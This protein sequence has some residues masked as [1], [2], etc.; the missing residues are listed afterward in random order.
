MERVG[1]CSLSMKTFK[2]NSLI[3]TDFNHISRA[4]YLKYRTERQWN[5]FYEN[6][7]KLTIPYI[8]NT[9]NLKTAEKNIFFYQDIKCLS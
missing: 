4:E 9:Y 3:I 2:L 5:L 1:R 6:N 7:F 8:K